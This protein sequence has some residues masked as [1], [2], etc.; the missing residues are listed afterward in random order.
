MVVTQSPTNDAEQF[1]THCPDESLLF[2]REIEAAVNQYF[3]L[4]ISKLEKPTFS[5]LKISINIGR[6]FW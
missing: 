1:L 6:Q 4:F 5:Y 3:Y 2:L